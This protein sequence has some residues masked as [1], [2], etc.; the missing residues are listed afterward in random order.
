MSFGVYLGNQNMNMNK[1]DQNMNGK[2][3]E[4][5]CNVYTKHCTMFIKIL[6]ELNAREVDIV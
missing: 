6:D 4:N 2:G 1:K 3:G 5:V